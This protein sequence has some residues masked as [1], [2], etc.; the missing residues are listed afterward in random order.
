MPIYLGGA[1]YS[2]NTIAGASSALAL[3]GNLVQPS[4]SAYS[5]TIGVQPAFNANGSG[6]WIYPSSFGGGGA[7]RELG[8]PVGWGVTQ[9]GAGSYGFSTS[10]GRYTAPV[11]GKYYF[12]SSAYYNI[13]SNSTSGYIHYQLAVNGNVTWNNSRTPYNIYGHG[14]LAQH[15]DGINVSAIMSLGVGDYVSIIPYWGGTIGRI[16]GS[17]TLFCGYLIG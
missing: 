13:D 3:T 10:T 1:T 5:T 14:E 6:A 12:H 17:Y 8:S 2:N 9:Q 16:Y 7:W 15:S 4:P 11:A